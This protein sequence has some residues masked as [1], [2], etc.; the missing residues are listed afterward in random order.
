[1]N[2]GIVGLMSGR[3]ERDFLRFPRIAAILY[4]YLMGAMPMEI[5]V[6]EIASDLVS[7]I[8]NGRILDVGTGPGRLLVE[9]H[10]LNPDL[11]L[12]GLD[13]SAAMIE[14]AM[15]NLASIRAEIQEGSIQ[16]TTYPPGSFDGITCTGSFY[17]WDHPVA[18]LNEIWRILRPGGSA[19]LYETHRQYDRGRLRQV[20]RKNLQEEN[21]IRRLCLPF[22]LLWQLR[23][24]Y[25][26]EEINL[27][28]KKTPF[29]GSYAIKPM[30]LAGLPI[31]LRI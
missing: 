4:D 27:I 10:R 13:I 22:L 31:W 17:L 2:Y 6:K 12:F 15:N 18:C 9:I 23:M 28:V 25:S 16:S 26:E 21:I 30:E 29:S 11:E 14:Q 5:Q 24:T 8:P 3:G 19:Y 7:R 1:M 20:V